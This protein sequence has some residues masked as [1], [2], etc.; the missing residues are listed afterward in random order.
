MVDHDIVLEE[1]SA[2]FDNV[3]WRK[4]A[5]GKELAYIDARDVAKRLDEVCGVNWQCK[6][7]HLNNGTAV[8]SIGILIDGEWVWRAD[9]SDETDIEASK[10]ALSRAFVRAASRW[11]IGR[12]LYD[13]KPK[14]GGKSHGKAW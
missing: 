5:G 11:G 8:C 13:L 10:G 1:L 7:E 4:G 2:E 14:A 9:G 3:R 12:Y 6:Y